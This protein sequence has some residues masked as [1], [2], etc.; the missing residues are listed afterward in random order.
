M[1]FQSALTIV[2][3]VCILCYRVATG[4]LHSPFPDIKT[5]DTVHIVNV[6]WGLIIA[7]FVLEIC[8][9]AGIFKSC[10][11]QIE[12]TKMSSTKFVYNKPKEKTEDFIFDPVIEEPW[13][14]DEVKLNLT[15]SISHLMLNSMMLIVVLLMRPHNVIMVPSIFITCQLTSKCMDHKLLDFKSAKRTDVVDVLSRTL[16][17]MWIGILFFFYQVRI[18]IIQCEIFIRE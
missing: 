14:I 11:V 5:W 16:V 17:H 10:G 8:T 2:A 13:N 9:Y 6:F 4:T 12:P 3:T 7:Q 15:R 1:Q 18:F